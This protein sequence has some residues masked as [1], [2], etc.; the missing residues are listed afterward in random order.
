MLSHTLVESFATQA[1]F[2]LKLEASPCAPLLPSPSACLRINRNLKTINYI[3]EGITRFV[4][5]GCV[6]DKNSA[7]GFFNV[8]YGNPML[9]AF[10]QLRRLVLS[11]RCSVLGK[12][13]V[14]FSV[15]ASDIVTANNSE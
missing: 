10:F 3:S 1:D 13:S 15:Q 8:V 4:S 14:S 7:L 12:A 9:T 5:S 2:L 11:D 6:C